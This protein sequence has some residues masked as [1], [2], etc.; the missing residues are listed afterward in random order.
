MITNPNISQFL[1]VSLKTEYDL[2][3]IVEKGLPTD[4]LQLL[5]EAGLTFTEVS[6]IIIS[7]RTLKHRKSRGEAL[8][9]EESD[10][11]VRMAR[12]IGQAESVFGNREKALLWLRTPDDR[13]DNQADRTP[14]SM[15][16]TE[17][18]GRLVEEM[19]WQIAEGIYT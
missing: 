5:R 7:P 19:L 11:V 8:S 6:E 3:R 16:R 15:L 14:L 18:G 9:N 10:R 17:S 1:G 4:G 12:V 2:P 13:L